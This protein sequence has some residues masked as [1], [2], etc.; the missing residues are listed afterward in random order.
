[1]NNRLGDCLTSAGFGLNDAQRPIRPGE[2]ITL[3]NQEI[4]CSLT[5]GEILNYD[6]RV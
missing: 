1:M 3:S 5:T 6:G 2:S 4:L